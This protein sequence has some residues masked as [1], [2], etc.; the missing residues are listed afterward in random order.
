MVL[1]NKKDYD[2][3]IDA[4][5]RALKLRPDYR[6]AA[7]WLA[8]VINEKEDWDGF[9]DD[10]KGDLQR[11]QG[12]WEQT[13]PEGNALPNGERIVKEV[14]GDKESVTWYGP[15]GEVTRSHRATIALKK[16]GTVR[17]LSF[18][19]MEMLHGPNKGQKVN[20]SGSYVYVINKDTF[21]EVVNVLE[22]H[23]PNPPAISV[24]RR[25]P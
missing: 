12:R 24:W 21:Y 1:R 15:D 22:S 6:P 11:M 9:T 17:T 13:T 3:A 7:T 2:G 8:Q 18:S 14:Q 25:V 5:R 10:P 20:V 19:D 4:Y 23:G 16:T